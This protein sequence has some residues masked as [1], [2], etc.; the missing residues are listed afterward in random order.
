MQ[1]QHTKETKFFTKKDIK[2]VL[3]A[4]FSGTFTAI[5]TFFF[6][7]KSIDYENSLEIINNNSSEI[8]LLV[9]AQHYYDQE[10]YLKVLTIYNLEKLNQNPIALNNMAYM[11][12]HGIYVK[13][14]IENARKYYKMASTLGNS[15]AENNWFLFNIAY[16]ESYENLLKILAQ[17]Y[18]S[19]NTVVEDFIKTY[20]CSED[21]DNALIYFYSLP[22]IEQI[23]VLELQMYYQKISKSDELYYGDSFIKYSELY[24]HPKEVTTGTEVIATLINGKKYLKSEL[25]STEVT[26]LDFDIYTKQFIYQ[27]NN[28]TT[29]ITIPIE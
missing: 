18:Y 12:E 22:L 6:T 9:E 1:M 5:I 20:Y 15:T 27:R 25:L 24:H 7:L 23:E 16:P 29:F 26:N 10:E 28:N 17:G 21:K 4:I 19:S 13:K 3:L 14:D 2:T 11:Y 8:E